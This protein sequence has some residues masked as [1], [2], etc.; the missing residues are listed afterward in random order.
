[1]S[2]RVCHGLVRFAPTRASSSSS[3]RPYPALRA[4]RWL[5]MSRSA[6]SAPLGQLAHVIED[7]LK[8]LLYKPPLLRE[9]FD[10]IA[11][12]AFPDRRLNRL[13][14]L[15]EHLRLLLHQGL[16]AFVRELI[17]CSKRFDVLALHFDHR[18]HIEMHR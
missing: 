15:V 12:V 17:G 11:G 8:G 3:T 10:R 7:L 13:N 6:T 18:G 14:P 4:G 9:C 2:E 1:M 16:H 5:P